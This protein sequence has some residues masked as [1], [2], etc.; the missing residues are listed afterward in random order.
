MIIKDIRI[1]NNK[2]FV[3]IAYNINTNK[4]ISEVV[5]LLSHYFSSIRLLDRVGVLLYG[6]T[7]A[8]VTI[9]SLKAKFSFIIIG[10]STSERQFYNTIVHELN[11][12]KDFICTYYDV[13]LVS[14]TASHLIGDM[15]GA[16][17]YAINN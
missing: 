16:I 3:K 8:G 14:E 13:P 11:H 15:F 10:K 4:D 9:T 6:E 7:N 12:V 5:S 1:D 2:W 17:Y